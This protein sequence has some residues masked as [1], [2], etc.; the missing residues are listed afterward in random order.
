MG[1]TDAITAGFNKYVTFTGRADRSEY[2]YWTLFSVIVQ[3]V[4]SILDAISN[5][6]F[7]AAVLSLAVLLPSL[8]VS[9]RRLHD[10]DRT[11]WW[12]LL[13]LT[14]I[15]AILLIVWDC[16]KGTDGPNRFGS[17]PLATL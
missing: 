4:G 17:D 3:V 6:G 11:G 1:F 13:V 15:G 10:L 7:I 8:A 9:V 16:F 5:L 2:W 14:G 12:M